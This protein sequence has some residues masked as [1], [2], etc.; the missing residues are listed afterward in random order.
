MEWIERRA[1]L[2][3]IGAIVVAAVALGV[4]IAD[5]DS[6]SDHHMIRIAGQGF[7]QPYGG[8]GFE[9][10]GPMLRRYDGGPSFA[11]PDGGP[12]VRGFERGQGR[13]LRGFE[14]APGFAGPLMGGPL[15]GEVTLPAPNG[16]YE[17]VD[18]QRGTVSQISAS[19]LTVRSS[20]G[21]TKTYAITKDLAKGIA[22]GDEVELRA[23]VTKGKATV[24]SLHAMRSVMR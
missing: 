5:G 15:H 3:G 24:T 12:M 21:F 10:G 17:T 13:G 11:A 19:S 2:I 20:D 6:H 23:T 8:P 4:A 14:G 9:G 1:G 7:A 16:K 18:L 22:K